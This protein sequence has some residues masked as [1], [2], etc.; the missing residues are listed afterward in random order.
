[1]VEALN[2]PKHGHVT[3]LPPM[4][5]A[6]LSLGGKVSDHAVCDADLRT[7]LLFTGVNVAQVPQKRAQRLRAIFAAH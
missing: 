7:T 2:S 3:D 1:L 5:R 4:L 6:Y